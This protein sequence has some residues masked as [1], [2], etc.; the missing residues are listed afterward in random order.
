MS[1][2]VNPNIVSTNVIEEPIDGWKIAKIVA[3]VAIA[4][5]ALTLLSS[6][7]AMMILGPATLPIGAVLLAT[8]GV[9]MASVFALAFS[10]KTDS[11]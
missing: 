4:L 5:F 7:I 3:V 1:L 11:I 2:S 6:G 9:M 8:G 10:I